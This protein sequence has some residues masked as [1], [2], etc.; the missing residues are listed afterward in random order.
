MSLISLL[1]D[2]YPA[3]SSVHAISALTFRSNGCQLVSLIPWCIVQLCRLDHPA[4]STCF[5]VAGPGHV[6]QGTLS[7]RVCRVLPPKSHMSVQVGVLRTYGG[8][9][10]APDSA[11]LLWAAMFGEVSTSYQRH[12]QMG[13]MRLGGG[14]LSSST[15]VLFLLFR[16]HAC[17]ELAHVPVPVVENPRLAKRWGRVSERARVLAHSGGRCEGPGTDSG[18][19]S[20]GKGTQGQS[21][22]R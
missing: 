7:K 5:S 18:W 14:L 11:S 1:L 17:E 3:M 9:G 19:M 10:M 16:S 8:R 4:A 22:T 6:S 21:M 12:Y 13:C 20:Q 2:G 15:S